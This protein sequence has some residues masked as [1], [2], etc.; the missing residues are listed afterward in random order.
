MPER[1]LLI[2]AVERAEKA[3]A[4]EFGGEDD[5]DP[6]VLIAREALDAR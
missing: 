5:P 3:E 6:V 1:D 4:E 2:E